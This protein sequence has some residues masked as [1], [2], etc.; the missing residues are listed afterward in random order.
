[1]VA[2]AGSQD[3]LFRLRRQERQL[4]RE[5][6]EC[7]QAVGERALEALAAGRPVE[8][9]S[10]EFNELFLEVARVERERRRVAARLEELRQ[11][12]AAAAA[13][14]DDSEPPARPGAPP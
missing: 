7:Y 4:E 5:L 11:V 12:V 2:A 8:T 3:E 1:M 6:E 14:E 13:A 9:D 10:R